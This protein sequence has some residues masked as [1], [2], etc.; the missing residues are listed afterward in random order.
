MPQPDGCIHALLCNA[1]PDILHSFDAMSS[2]LSSRILLHLQT[3]GADPSIRTENYDPYLSPGLKL[4]IDVALEDADIRAKLK[5]LDK[6]Y[7]KVC[8]ILC[9]HSYFIC[10][11]SSAM[12]ESGDMQAGSA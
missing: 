9:A 8:T 11:P 6:K 7:A 5:A 12:P 4:P 2:P 3:R 1:G 10:D